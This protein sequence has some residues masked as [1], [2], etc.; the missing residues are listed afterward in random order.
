MPVDWAVTQNNLGTV[1]HTRGERA[2]G[3]AAITLLEGAIQSYRFALEVF[4]KPGMEYH[5]NRTRENL[6]SAERNLTEK[7][8]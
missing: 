2:Y 6:A 5:A 4:S 8:K 7:S 3:H 1:L